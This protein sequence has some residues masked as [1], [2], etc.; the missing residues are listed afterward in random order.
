MVLEASADSSWTRINVAG[1]ILPD[2]ASACVAESPWW[3]GGSSGGWGD[4]GSNTKWDCSSDKRDPK[5]D[6]SSADW[7]D[8][9]DNN[10]YGS[11]DKWGSASDQK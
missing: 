4:G 3:R 11:S 8:P 1:A 5:V 10:D 7:G 2:K 9:C 6:G